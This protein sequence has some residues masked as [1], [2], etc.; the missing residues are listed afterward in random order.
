MSKKLHLEAGDPCLSPPCLPPG[1][2]SP[3]AVWFA[4]GLEVTAFL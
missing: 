3:S 2:L 1:H 4:V